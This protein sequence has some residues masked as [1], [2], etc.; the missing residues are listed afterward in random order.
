M[1]D[2]TI[3]TARTS[4]R[5]SLLEGGWSWLADPRLG[6]AAAFAL[7]LAVVVLSSP[8]G[9]PLGTGQEALAYWSAQL[10]DPYA[11]SE[12][13]I[14]PGYVYS[15]AFLLLVSPLKWL[16]WVAF[17]GA[18]TAI[19]LVALR[20]LTGGRW[21]LL[22]V[23]AATMEIA[24]GN[25]SLLLGLAIVV[26]FRWPAAW[27]FVLLT[28]ITPGV[29]LL[30]FVV[31]REWRSLGIALGATALIVAGSAVLMPGA[32]LEWMDVLVRASGYSATSAAVPIPFIVR[33]PI[34]VV[35]VV[36]GAR[37]DRRW[38]VPVASMLALPALWYGSLTMLLAV[39]PLLDGVRDGRPPARAGEHREHEASG[40]AAAT[41]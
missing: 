22:G 4:R 10:A 19:L 7:W 11:N 23:L 6:A 38:T 28:K 34:A 39:I 37:T 27:A 36:W 3:A 9:R 16:P 26:G 29:G 24:G 17:M 15:P 21:F 41:A 1:T 13:T 40:E 8:I 12:W 25:I 2:P 32:W 5:P 18:W 30:W 33:F 20:T 31:R 14:P 35:L